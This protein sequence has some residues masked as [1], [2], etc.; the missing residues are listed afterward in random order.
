MSDRGWIE[1]IDVMGWM[2]DD[3]MGDLAGYCEPKL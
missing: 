3:V 1:G 2:T